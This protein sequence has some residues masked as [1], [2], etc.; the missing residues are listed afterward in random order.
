[1][2][3]VYHGAAIDGDGGGGGG[4]GSPY[5]SRFPAPS[6]LVVSLS[7][8]GV[9]L[10]KLATK[11]STRVSDGPPPASLPRPY[12]VREQPIY[13]LAPSRLSV[14]LGAFCLNTLGHCRAHWRP[15]FL[16]GSSCCGAIADWRL[17][18]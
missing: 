14:A 3:Q 16:P 11:T 5:P 18:R 15:C 8:Q 10:N 6:L 7:P 17:M 2:G 9:S 4:G 1:M 12:K 13:I